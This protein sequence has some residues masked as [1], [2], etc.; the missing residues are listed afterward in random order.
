LPCLEEGKDS[1]TEMRFTTYPE[2][3]PDK[4]LL[5][6][7]HEQDRSRPKSKEAIGLTPIASIPTEG[8]KQVV[9]F[10]NRGFDIGGLLTYAKWL[11]G[12]YVGG[13]TPLVGGRCI[14]KVQEWLDS[15]SHCWPC[16]YVDIAEWIQDAI[17]EEIGRCCCPCRCHTR[18]EMESDT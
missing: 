1:E 12:K 17:A 5:C 4:R 13:N 7:Y 10:L 18:G 2:F 15:E 14:A 3:L 11:D 16:F 8:H 9:T 6:T